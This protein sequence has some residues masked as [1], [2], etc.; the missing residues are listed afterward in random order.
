MPLAKADGESFRELAVCDPYDEVVYRAL[1]GRVAPAVEA[2]LGPEVMSYRVAE[3]GP[4]WRLRSRKYD[5]S[6]RLLVSAAQMNAGFAGLG[7]LDVRGYYPSI[8]PDA[9]AKVLSSIGLPDSEIEPLKGYLDA[10]A[11]WGIRGLPVGPEASGALGNAFLIPVDRRL[12]NLAVCFCRYTE[13]IWIMP[14][15]A[16][17]FE[18][19]RAAVQEEAREL[20]LESGR[21]SHLATP[22][23]STADLR[24]A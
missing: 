15:E 19:L 11:D 6:R 23:I 3:S 10:W 18:W 17:A 7:T 21:P 22:G 13:D 2:A 1:V 24:R 5:D 4:E 12:R 14:G 9:L 16:A 20:G 8:R